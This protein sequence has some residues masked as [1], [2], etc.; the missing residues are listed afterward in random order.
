MS[1][2]KHDVFNETETLFNSSFS[3]NGLEID[4]LTH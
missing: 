1:K 4:I 3:L 2:K